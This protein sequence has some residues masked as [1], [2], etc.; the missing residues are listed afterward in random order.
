[1]PKPKTLQKSERFV[2]SKGVVL[3]VSVEEYEFEGK[4]YPKLQIK[5][6]RQDSDGYPTEKPK[7]VNLPVEMKANL[8]KALNQ[9]K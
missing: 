9:I 5:T 7:S 6:F 2:N 3:E 4:K 1:M 8:I